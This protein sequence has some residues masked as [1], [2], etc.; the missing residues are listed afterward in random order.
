MLFHTPTFLIFFIVFSA[1]YFSAR[2][3]AMRISVLLVFSNLFYGWWDW[4]YLL[5]L[6]L[7]IFVDYYVANAMGRTE[8]DRQ[9]KG[10]VTL[11]LATNLV[12]LGIFK[13]FNFFISSFESIGL[14]VSNWYLG[15]LL[16]PVGLSFYTFVSI[17]YTVDVY[18]KKQE[19]VKNLLEYAAF[20]C[21]FPQLVA[22]PIE[23]V[24]HLLPQI[25][26]PLPLTRARVSEGTLL[27][28]LGFFRK[29]MADTFAIMINPVF[30][31]L[32]AATPAEVVFSIFGFGLQ[33]YLDFSGYTDMARG[34]SKVMGI[35]LMVNFKT[36][37]L[38]RSPQE[39]WRRWHI[40]LSTWLRDYLYISL[41][42][43]RQ[44]L[45]RHLRNLMI[46]MMLGGLWHGA[47]FN[48]IIW[49][50]LHGAY[51]CVNLLVVRFQGKPIAQS[52]F[53]FFT[54]ILGWASTFLLVNYT[55]LY[56][57]CQTFSDAML[58]NKKIMDW[59]SDPALPTVF[60]GVV[61]IVLVIIG[62]D[63]SVRINE[64]YSN[65]VQFKDS[66]TI[67]I[68]YGTVSGFL[69]IAGLVFLLGVPTQQFIYFQF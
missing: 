3:N 24:G 44:G 9:R 15:E 53:G 20:V 19:P 27:F 17:S 56:F 14:D 50:A 4:R 7:T 57:R 1:F 23:R 52:N 32:S 58:A 68:V 54:A 49:G 36:P 33:I 45:P 41:G 62:I 8:S 63:V 28:C 40:S 47:G 11:S 10:L 2:G 5:L 34:I 16:L 29:S 66:N 35:D 37:Y 26:N 59:L 69:F 18:R 64:Y 21:Y 39:F 13:Y 60:P 42:G 12:I 43:N 6:W 46:T 48:F 61:I 30:Q 67:A 55:W 25:L 51:L 38:S 22:G 65:R 31:N